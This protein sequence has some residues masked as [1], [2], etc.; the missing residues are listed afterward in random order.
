[1]YTQFDPEKQQEL[2][3]AQKQQMA[4]VSNTGSTMIPSQLDP[5]AQNGPSLMQKESILPDSERQ[6]FLTIS[7]ANQ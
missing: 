6:D 4:Q 3:E 7:P 2:M 1:M 5:Q